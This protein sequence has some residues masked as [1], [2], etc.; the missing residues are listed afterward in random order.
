QGM[1]YVR[2]VPAG[3]RDAYVNEVRGEGYGDFDLRPSQLR[4]EYSSVHFL[5]PF[6]DEA[7]RIFG[8][9]MLT[10]TVLKQ[11]MERARDSGEPA[12]SGKTRVL[13]DGGA[14]AATTVLV[15]YPVYS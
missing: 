4:K 6:S 1:A 14:M 15:F 12:F 11:P 8:H 2:W 5:E 7:R 10:D 9:D 3:G 13:G